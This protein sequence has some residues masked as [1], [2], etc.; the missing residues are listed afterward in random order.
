[1]F[2]YLFDSF[3]GIEIYTLASLFFFLAFFI[4]ILY[5]VIRMDKAHIRK[6]AQLPLDSIKNEGDKNND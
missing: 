1:M 3:P 6:V 2:K 4:I 5:W